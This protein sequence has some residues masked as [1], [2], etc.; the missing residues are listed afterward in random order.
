[1]VIKRKIAIHTKNHQVLLDSTNNIPFTY[2]YFNEK[3]KIDR[4]FVISC[5]GI[6]SSR[7]NYICNVKLS[8]WK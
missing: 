1:M 3:R 6:A 2:R 4:N 8:Y 7:N 5:M